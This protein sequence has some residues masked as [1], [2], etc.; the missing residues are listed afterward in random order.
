MKHFLKK[1]KKSKSIRKNYLLFFFRVYNNYC[2]CIL[3]SL[4]KIFHYTKIQQRTTL[5]KYWM[6]LDLLFLFFHF[7]IVPACSAVFFDSL[8]PHGL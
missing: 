8:Q 1:K 5:L 4:I 6:H 2:S 3:F 7:N